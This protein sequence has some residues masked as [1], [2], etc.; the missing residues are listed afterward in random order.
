MTEPES[1]TTGSSRHP[2]RDS[3][4]EPVE[5]HLYRQSSFKADVHLTVDRKVNQQRIVPDGGGRNNN[6]VH[7]GIDREGGHE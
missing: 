6:S 5:H 7:T 4:G 1:E 3:R 2:R